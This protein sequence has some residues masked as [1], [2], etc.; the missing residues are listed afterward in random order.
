MTAE[1]CLDEKIA[2]GRVS[3]LA[4]RKIKAIIAEAKAAE[5]AG[6]PVAA[7]AAMDKALIAVK[8][9]ATAKL[10]RSLGNIDAQMRLRTES[11]EMKAEF[12]KLREEGHGPF[13]QLTLS[14]Y[15]GKASELWLYVQSKLYGDTL[16]DVGNRW[17]NVHYLAR[18]LRGEAHAAFAQAIEHLRPKAL[19]LKREAMRET[20]VLAALYGDHR[21][22]EAAS[23]AKSWDAAAEKVRG[24][25]NQA[26]GYEAIPRREGWALPNP[27]MAAAKVMSWT[28]QAFE[29]R[30]APLLAREK[31]IDFATGS[32]MSD[33]KLSS[34]LGDVHETGRTGGAEGGPSAGFVGEGPLS[35]RRSASRTLIFKDAESWQKFNDLFGSGRGPFDTMMSHLHAMTHDAAMMRVFGPDP[36]ASKR[37]IESMFERE[38]A[39]LAR[40]GD[41]ANPKD[42]AAALKE[43]RANQ[44][45]VESGLG[46]FRDGWANMTGETGIPVNVRFA[47]IMGNIRHVLGA[48]QL[49]TSIISA[50]SDGGLVAGTTKMN[51]LPITDVMARITKMFAEGG[52]EI[53]AAQHGLLLDT[54]AHGAREAD[55]FMGQTIKTNAAAKMS[56]AVIRSIGHRVWT[57]KIRD[58]FALEY[59]AKMAAAIERKTPY[60]ELSFGHKL[61]SY[62]VT[63]EDWARVAKEVELNEPR[64]GAALLRPM[65]VRATPGLEPVGERLGRLIQQEMDHTA[66]EGNPMTRRIAIGSTRPGTVAGEVM[67]S[68]ALYRSWPVTVFNMNLNRTF[69]RGWDGARLAHGAFTFIAM[70]L[71][72]A[73]AMQ[74]KQIVSGR[75]P[76]SLDPTT[77]EGLF[78]WGHAVMQG[79]G[80][81]VFGDMLGADKTRRGDSWASM[82]A[83]PVANMAEDVGGT[84]LL[85]NLQLLAEGKPTNFAGEAFWTASRYLPGSNVFYAKLAF[86]RE[87]IDQLGLMI[88][89][90]APERFARIEAAARKNYGQG[91]WW[92]HGQTAPDR[93][94]NLAAVAGGP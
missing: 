40:Q 31:M 32:P 26:A 94:P 89:P 87:V 44:S 12:A 93:A 45:R 49:G 62:G 8:H 88:D 23:V 82:I 90:K 20:D 72:G 59:M 30:V 15:Q 51:G 2:I 54:L 48:S 66:I 13:K 63:K 38:P 7:R 28:R 25:F 37:F 78:G 3:K 5:A 64:P 81:G 86:Q 4:G 43:N 55:V 57:G 34:V 73:A 61:A 35:S 92:R 58:G 77:A 65:D 74:A 22:P 67:R 85:R 18:A 53:N 24:D 60:E 14:Q 47:E 29:A 50:I 11:A 21:S 36:G 9:E 19:G 46:K 33:A 10:A 17:N 70:T 16:L 68:L 91:S 69:A 1:K 56:T 6:D 83:G 76:K 79:G 39:A 71:L 27:D 42:M 41:E 84:F 75:D 80:L 52:A